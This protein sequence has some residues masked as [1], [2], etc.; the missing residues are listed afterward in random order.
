MIGAA[1]AVHGMDLGNN[2][3][4]KNVDKKEFYLSIHSKNED[5]ETLNRVANLL[6]EYGERLHGN[7]ASEAYYQEHMECLIPN[8]ALE[9]LQTV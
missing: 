7:M 8:S 2:S 4:Y 5:M 9:K 1:K 3:L 6:L